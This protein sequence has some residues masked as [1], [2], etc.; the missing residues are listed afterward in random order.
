ME[1]SNN[2]NLN[3]FN[4]FRRFN[5]YQLQYLFTNFDV[6]SY[7]RFRVEMDLINNEYHNVPKPKPVLSP[8]PK[9]P[10]TQV[11]KF[12]HVYNDTEERQESIF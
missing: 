1:H 9:P 12:A 2:S 5:Y 6:D 10:T 8:Q 4:M 7:Y 11:A 3:I